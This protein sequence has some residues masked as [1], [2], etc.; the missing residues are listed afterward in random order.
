VLFVAQFVTPHSL[1]PRN[2]FSVAYF[3]VAGLFAVRQFFE[4]R[5][6]ARVR[7]GDAEVPPPSQEPPP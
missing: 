2:D 1:V 6:Y 4:M 5:P 3:V 7:S